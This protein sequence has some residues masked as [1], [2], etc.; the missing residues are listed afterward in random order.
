MWETPGKC[1]RA[2]YRRTQGTAHQVPI[3]AGSARISLPS[4]CCHRLDSMRTAAAGKSDG[5][6]LSEQVDEVWRAIQRIAATAPD[7]ARLQGQTRWE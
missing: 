6:P 2:A 3:R 7:V 5:Q 4:T 1:L